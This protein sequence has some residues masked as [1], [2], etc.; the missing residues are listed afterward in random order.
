[1]TNRSTGG[2]GHG[3]GVSPDDGRNIDPTLGILEGEGAQQQVPEDRGRSEGGPPV[4]VWEAPPTQTTRLS[5]TEPTYYDRP[6]LKRPVWMWAVPAYFFTG[7]TAGAAAVLGAA[8]QASGRDELGGLISRC[9]WIAATGVAL[10]TGLL[11]YDLGR[12]ERFLNMLRVFRPSSPLNVGS[13]VLAASG[14]LTA[15]SAILSGGAGAL[16]AIGDTAGVAAGVVGLPL[17][18]YT[19]VLVSTT[20][21]PVWS[22]VRRSLPA[23]FV[24]SAVSGA[25]SCLQLMKLN[26]RERSIA[27]R[28]AI[29]GAAADLAAHGAVEREAGRVEGV[30]QA[31]HEGRAGGLLRAAKGL[32]AGSLLVN[33]LPG[34]ARWKRAIAGILGVMGS[35]ATKF[36]VFYA[37]EHSALDPRATFRQQRSG[38]GAAE[39][40]GL[41]AVTGPDERAVRAD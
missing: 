7:G 37:G 23:L 24:A 36:G 16:G 31:L 14:P 19:S 33:L 30:A 32:T 20:A 38:H 6:L 34:S 15:G 25:A 41:A 17:S 39:V 29:V 3:R 13:W 10:G 35:A 8:A 2:P 22:E 26:R 11:V 27:R 5:A 4:G 18:G 9:R 12:P 28:F 21:V 1:M 40:T